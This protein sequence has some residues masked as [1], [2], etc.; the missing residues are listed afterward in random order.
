MFATLVAIRDTRSVPS[1]PPPTHPYLEWDHPIPFAHRGGA[2]DAPEN[3]MPAF[4]VAVDLGY[5]YVETDVQVTSDGVLL[6]FHDFNLQRT[7]GINRRVAEMTWA[8]VQLAR[9]SGVAP[10]P[11]LEELLVT[12]PQL[13]VNIDCKTDS[14]VDALVS[15]LRRNNA[16]DRVCV[17]AFSDR[18]IRRLRAILGPDLCTALGPGAVAALRYGRLARAP[19]QAAQVPVRQGPLV[20]TTPAFVDRAHRA[21]IHVHV[22]TI[23]EPAEMRRLLDMGVDGIMTDRPAVLREV[24]E[25]RGEWRS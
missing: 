1:T 17:G 6:A 5:R 18:R 25:D 9:V 7:C 3:T 13:R 22:W 2:S 16:L 15:A 8:E 20:V 12:W 10:I 14:A 23:D 4:Q 19:A 24:L 21:G 11:T